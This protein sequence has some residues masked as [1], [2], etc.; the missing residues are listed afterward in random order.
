MA[1]PASGKPRRTRRRRKGG[2]RSRTDLLNGIL[3]VRLKDGTYR[4][5]ASIPAGQRGKRGW[6]PTVKTPE[7]A[8]ELRRRTMAKLD[9]L[10]P[11]TLTFSP[12]ARPSSPKQPAPRLVR[13]CP[14]VGAVSGARRGGTCGSSCNAKAR[15][16]ASSRS[17]RTFQWADLG[18][19]NDA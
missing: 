16:A 5:R 2:K 3:E 11:M 6:T 15:T 10:P 9:E 1:A 12:R 13:D 7:L 4:Y 8:A 17:S 14:A 18:G 19:Q